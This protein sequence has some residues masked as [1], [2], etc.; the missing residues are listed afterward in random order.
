[1]HNDIYQVDSHDDN[2]RW[3]TRT[4]TAYHI[5]AWKCPT[6]LLHGGLDSSLQV[7]SKDWHTYRNL[8]ICNSGISPRIICVHSIC[9][10]K[11][12]CVPTF[13]TQLKL[14]ISTNYE[15]IQSN[16]VFSE[17]KLILSKYSKASSKP[18]SRL[19]FRIL[20]KT[21]CRNDTSINITCLTLTD[22]ILLSNLSQAAARDP[23]QF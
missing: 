23:L 5:G 16:G 9:R 10:F 4:T 7:T 22:R 20:G 6:T 8:W 2:Q 15:I 13:V 21:K 12:N 19:V 18:W 3:K 11:K 1:M 17:S 14:V